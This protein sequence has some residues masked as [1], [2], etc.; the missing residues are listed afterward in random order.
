MRIERGR[1]E[2][3]VSLRQPPENHKL[4]DDR[5]RVIG[6]SHC[7]RKCLVV[8]DDKKWTFVKDWIDLAEFAVW[9]SHPLYPVI[10]LPANL[11]KRR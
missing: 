9:K 6:C 10:E 3:P 2:M 5:E 4:D 8:W 11:K 1:D 7:G